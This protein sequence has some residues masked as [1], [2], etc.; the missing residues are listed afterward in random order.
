[1]N[2]NQSSDGPA[3]LFVACVWIAGWAIW[4]F[5]HQQITNAFGWL[6]YEELQLIGM[7][8]TDQ[9]TSR[10]IGGWMKYLSD[11]Q[12]P[13]Q[14]PY[15]EK[16]SGLTGHYLRYPVSALL[17]LLAYFAM[18]KAPRSSFKKTYTLDRL[19]AAQARVWPVITPIVKFNPAQ[20]NAR[21]PDSR[22][23]IPADLPV[24]A[25]ALSPEE[26]LRWH[27]I[28]P[29]D[30]VEHEHTTDPLDREGTFYAFAQQ[31]GPRWRGPMSLPWHSKALFAAFALKIARKREEADDLLG[32][33][34]RAVNPKKG[35]AFKPGPVLRRNIMK[36]IEDPKLGG[37]AAKIA[38]QH[39]YVA[40]ALLRL[41]AHARERGGV[42]AP[43]Q[44]LWLRGADR[45]LWYP[46]NNLGRQ[47]FHTEAAGAIAHYLAEVTAGTPLLSPKVEKAVS[48]IEEYARHKQRSFMPVLAE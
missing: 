27:K 12:Q 31:L 3:F 34:A 28:A 17:L 46:L 25:E 4:H 42:M 29:F 43:A 41:L 38:R 48:T 24:F 20:D 8:I 47:S 15:I 21:D 44:F 22:E 19:I 14:W 26:W 10:L 39:A 35:M 33:V 45:A 13:I 18:F 6:R 9:R 36:I 23:P 1:M 37:E 40:P 2:Q 16:V 30:T 32:E 7:F 5:F 11:K